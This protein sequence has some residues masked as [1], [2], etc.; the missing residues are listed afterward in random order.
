MKITKLWKKLAIGF[1]GA[2]I[3]A[4]IVIYIFVN[5][6]INTSFR[7]YVGDRERASYQ[8][9][10]RSVAAIYLKSGG[11]DGRLQ[12]AL[13]HVSTISSV[14]I[15]VVDAQGGVVAETVDRSRQDSFID[16]IARAVGGS[17]FV[18]D[19]LQERVEV[20]IVSRNQ[21]VGTVYITPVAKPAQLEQDS[22]FRQSLNS[23]LILGG[24]LAALVALTLSFLISARLTSPLAQI[25][26]AA[27]KL[28][29][30]DLGQRV[31][32]RENDEIGQLGEAFNNMASALQTHETLRKNMTADI[33][34]EL[35]T[36]LSTIRSHVEAY[37][38]GVMKPNK[39][40]LHSI[41]EEILRLGRLIDDLGELAQAE[42]GKL[43]LDKKEID[44]ALLAKNTVASLKPVFDG[45]ELT[46]KIKSKGEVVGVYD[47]DRIK[48]ILVN[49]LVNAVKYSSAGGQVTVEVG[50]V[51]NK[52]WISVSD[53]GPGID[54]KSLP[55]IFER[56]Y[57]V[58][59]SRNRATGG[60]GIGLTIAKELA[61][62]HG[63]SIDVSS[64]V[65]AGS[66][67]TVNFP[68][69]ITKKQKF[70]KPA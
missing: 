41:Y 44:L 66:T 18:G 23:S 10:G 3:A 37:Q 55:F 46:I 51:K 17:Q 39:K 4:M 26:K 24:I 31:D 61:K 53:N 30:G 33:A 6:F 54:E 2:A 42:S 47:E 7:G 57:R 62:L 9:I 8:R 38:D 15:E 29:D 43:K 68:R 65:G 63:G 1:M 16:N 22:L 40:N 56:F 60:S 21:R 13:P 69:K 52:A 67:F 36:P 12:D 28:E 48:Q 25:T 58:D 32:L 14:A 5:L 34:H 20:P 35:R 19:W 11:W 64:T 27:R 70:T 49:L 59:K 45:E 50:V